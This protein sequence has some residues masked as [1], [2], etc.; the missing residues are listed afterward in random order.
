ML[1]VAMISEIKPVTASK[2]E[3]PYKIEEGKLFY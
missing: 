3:N 1:V 2:Q